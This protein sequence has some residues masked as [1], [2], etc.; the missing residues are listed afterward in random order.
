MPNHVHLI[1]AIN[2]NEL[3][4][5]GQARGPVPTQLSLSDIIQRL[6]TLNNIREYVINNPANWAKDE[7]NPDNIDKS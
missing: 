4:D 6:K 3:L 2:E 1:I 5:N 7:E